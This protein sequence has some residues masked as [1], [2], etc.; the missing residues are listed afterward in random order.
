MKDLDQLQNTKRGKRLSKKFAPFFDD[1]SFFDDSIEEILP[2]SPTEKL[3]RIA[4]EIQN[5]KDPKVLYFKK[6]RLFNF[7]ITDRFN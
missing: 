2:E 7:I 1:A 5:V 3:S 6:S 4:K